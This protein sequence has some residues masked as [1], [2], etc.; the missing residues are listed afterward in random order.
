[1]WSLSTSEQRSNLFQAP[2]EL[3]FEGKGHIVNSVCTSV[4]PVLYLGNLLLNTKFLILYKGHKL[5]DE[6][7][8]SAAVAYMSNLLYFQLLQLKTTKSS[9]DE[10]LSALQEQLE[11]LEPV[12]NKVRRK[13]PPHSMPS[14]LATFSASH[15]LGTT[16]DVSA[17]KWG[18]QR[19]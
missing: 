16:L 3:S 17:I 7:V 12:K 19:M 9:E 6:K 13:P 5:A 11:Q 15:S 18:F 2:S 1:M 4:T 10:K 14:L 8:Y